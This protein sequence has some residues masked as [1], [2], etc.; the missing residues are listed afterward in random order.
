MAGGARTILLSRWR[1]GGETS[2]D[3]VREFAQELPHTTAAE[4][5][6]RSVLLTMD[7]PLDPNLEPRLTVKVSD[8]PTNATNPFFWS[9]YL[10]IDSGTPPERAEKPAEPE[11]EDEAEEDVE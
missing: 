10:L 2:F 8:Q 5:W 7:S 4:S 6:Q 9:G 1:T 3:L 11:P